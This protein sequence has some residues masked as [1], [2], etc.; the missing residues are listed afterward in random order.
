VNQCWFEVRYIFDSMEAAVTTQR[1]EN[2]QFS[3]HLRMEL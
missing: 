1:A 3:M 2:H